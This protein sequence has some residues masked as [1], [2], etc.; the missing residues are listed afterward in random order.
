MDPRDYHLVRNVRPGESTNTCPEQACAFLLGG[1]GIICLL[2]N[3][4]LL[5]FSES[6]MSL[7]YARDQCESKDTNKLRELSMMYLCFCHLI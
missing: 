1:E 4:K 2:T 3:I 7:G 6:L 5:E